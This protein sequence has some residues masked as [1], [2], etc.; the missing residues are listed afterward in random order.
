[1]VLA[2]TSTRI[3]QFLA[4]LRNSPHSIL[5]LDYDGTLAPFRQQRHLAL[6]YPGLSALL[7]DIMRDGHT[8]VVVVT[9]R[10]AYDV[11]PLLGIYPYPEIWGSHGLERLRPD[12][13]YEVAKVDPGVE[14]ALAAAGD[15]LREQN[16]Q[17][18]AELKP[19][20]VTLH[21]RGLAPQDAAN[22]RQQAISG[23]EP[24]AQRAGISLM[25]FDGGLEIRFGGRTK[26]YAVRT[27]LGE[28]NPRT[29]AAYL[30][31]DQTDEDAFRELRPRG[32]T[33]LCRPEWRETSAEVWLR[34]PGELLDFF[35]RWLRVYREF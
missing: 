24:L 3:E 9:G 28:S 26:G 33:V 14:D 35:S 27:V 7:K 19:G 22:I 18:H 21:W 10:T 25:E 5:L 17:Q 1:M 29:P 4:E 2:V 11:I 15:W 12:G 16:L 31:D 30:G 20:S 32:L 13:T 6:P 23:W 8:R 34:P